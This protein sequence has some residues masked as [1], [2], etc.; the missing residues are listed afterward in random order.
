MAKGKPPKLDLLKLYSEQNTA[1]WNEFLKNC[2]DRRD[3][4]TLEKMLYG[5]QLG[6]DDLVKKKMNTDKV[7]IWFL[8]LQRSIENTMKQIIKARMPNPLDNP[9][10]A[11]KFIQKIGEK[12]HRDEQIERY[13]KKVRF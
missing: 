2:L 13:L 8:R 11:S 4:E 5:A 10:N 1:R 7:N 6:M 12:R 3:L 9:L